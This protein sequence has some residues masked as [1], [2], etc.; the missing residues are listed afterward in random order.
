MV[1]TLSARAQKILENLLPSPQPI[2][3]QTLADQLNCSRRTIGRALKELKE[4]G[5]LVDLKRRHTNRCK[6]YLLTPRLQQASEVKINPHPKPLPEG[7]EISPEAAHQLK[8]YRFTFEA[9]FKEWP[10]WEKYYPQVSHE[11]A[12]VTD[13]N[14]LFRQT[15]DR[16]Y[17][18]R[19]SQVAISCNS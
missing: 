7:E 5:L 3:Q 9:N 18:I 2:R 19:D 14:L 16:L 1:E 17:T 11:L 10:D 12:H 6:M 13:P 8:L 4:A 15:F